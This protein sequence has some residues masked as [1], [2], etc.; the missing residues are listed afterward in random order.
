M[1]IILKRIVL[2]SVTF[3]STIAT[4][5]ELKTKTNEPIKYGALLTLSGDVNYL[6]ERCRKAMT[7]AEEDVNAAGGIQGRPL[8]VIIEDFGTLNLS[9]AVM[10]ANKLIDIDKVSAIF[11]GVLEDTEAI[12]PIAEQKHIPLMATGCGGVNVGKFGPNVF[13]ATNTDHILV[14]KLLAYA[15]Q[16]Q[17]QKLCLAYGDTSYFE[18]M[19]EDFRNSVGEYNLTLLPVQFP[20]GSNDTKAIAVKIQR[21]ECDAILAFHMPSSVLQLLENLRSKKI[22]TPFLAPHY[23]DVVAI[24]KALGNS[25]GEFIAAEYALPQKSFVTRFEERFNEAPLMPAGTCYDAVAVMAHVMNKSGTEWSAVNATLHNLKDYPGMS[26]NFTILPNG[27][28]VGQIV[29][30]RKLT[31]DGQ[32]IEELAP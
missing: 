15:Q 7:L 12:A 27:D 11:P 26:G 31:S 1:L 25:I 18:S 17:Y 16:H 2:I 21:L 5:Q 22:M 14:E 32:R 6:A 28:R 30:L 24:G 4:A 19:A 8:K 10:A 13:R 29:A 9:R 3:I 20:V 23:L